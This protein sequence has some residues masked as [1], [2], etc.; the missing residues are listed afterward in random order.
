VMKVFYYYYYLFYK[1]ILLDPDPRLAATL[2]LTALESFFLIGFLDVILAYC[3]CW[4][5]TK[6]YMVAILAI[7]LLVNTFYFFTSKKVKE[8]VKSKPV[9]L[10]NH[11]LTIA[12]ILLF[13]LVVISTL[14]WTGDYV[15]TIIA[16]CH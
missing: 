2:G 7:T 16:N 14:F 11:R 9:F 5:L 3:F 1:K 4:E 13:S 12:V 6:Y 10:N 15:N 8:I